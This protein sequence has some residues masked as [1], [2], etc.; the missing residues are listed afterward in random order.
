MS[1]LS[2]LDGEVSIIY[3]LN[4]GKAQR[5][6]LK[7]IFPVRIARKGCNALPIHMTTTKIILCEVAWRSSSKEK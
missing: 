5:Y 6:I 7:S 1:V 3:C 2:L 4:F